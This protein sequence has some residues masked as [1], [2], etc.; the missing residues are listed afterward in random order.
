MTEVSPSPSSIVF[1]AKAIMQI[2]PHR[3]PILLVD[4]VIYLNLEEGVII[5]Q[6]NVTHN[7][8]F[9]QGHFPKIPIMPGVL[10]LEALA[11]AAG[12]LMHQKGYS[13]KIALLLSVNNAKFR[14]P[15]TPGDVLHLHATCVHASNTGGRIQARAMVGDTVAVAAEIG[16]VMT[17]K[18]QLYSNGLN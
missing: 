7:E 6:K 4:R 9:F 12:I 18:E 2:L 3:Y 8:P 5:G 17:D 1:D 15:V 16:F 14:R 11:Q 10:V 13:D